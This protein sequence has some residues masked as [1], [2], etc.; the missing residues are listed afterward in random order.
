L[1]LCPLARASPLPR[2]PRNPPRAAPP[3]AAGPAPTRFDDPAIREAGAGV[4]NFGVA[5]EDAG[6]LS[7]K[8]VSVVLME[9]NISLTPGD[10]S[11]TYINV[12]SPS[13]SPP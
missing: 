9:Y 8:E 6:G 12:V 11:R 5:L 4:K 3:R 2:V 13:K 10:H 1:T 7:T